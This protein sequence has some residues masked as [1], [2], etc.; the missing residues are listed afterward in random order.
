MKEMKIWMLTAILTFCG[1]TM[2]TSCSDEDEVTLPNPE[3]PVEIKCVKPDYLGLGDKVALI[4][5][6][7]TSLR[8]RTWKRL[9]TYCADGDWSLL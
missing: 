5:P 3:R 6:Y 1:L 7:R 8:W 2:L 9:P 4:S